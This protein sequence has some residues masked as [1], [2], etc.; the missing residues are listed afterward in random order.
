MRVLVHICCGPCSIT[1]LQRLRSMGHEPV[2][3]FFNPNVQP[4][5]EY[6]RRREG[7]IMAAE[8][9]GVPLIPADV[10]PQG[11]QIWED[12]WLERAGSVFGDGMEFSA[13]TAP[14]GPVSMK[15]LPPAV[16]PVFWLRAVAGHEERRCRFCWRMRLRKT[17]ALAQLWNISAVTTSLLYSIYQDHEWIRIMG[18]SMAA[19]AGLDFIY[20]DFR[21]SWQEGA[22]LSKTMGIYRQPYCGCI[23]SEYDRYAAK[24]R[25]LFDLK[26]PEI[27]RAGPE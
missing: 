13:S 26:H 9:L 6:M 18:E 19:E 8:Q 25:R 21:S 22:T 20:E 11:E 4:L 16:N 3:L 1:V 12:S 24:S 17:V 2:G 14:Q 23:F 10:L 5:A 15:D 27:P 7:A